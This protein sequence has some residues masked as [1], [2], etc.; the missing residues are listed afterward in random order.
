MVAELFR[1]IDQDRT[2]LITWRQGRCLPYGDRIAFW[3]LGEI[4]KA[5][6]GILESDSVEE[7]RDKLAV[8][9]RA[10]GSVDTSEQEWLLS[11]LAPLVGAE[12]TGKAS[13]KNRSPP[14]VDSWR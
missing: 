12:S 3:A 10:T 5:H 8:A 2:E 13:K 9:L 14:G 4:V 6:A 7:A 11:R 1:F